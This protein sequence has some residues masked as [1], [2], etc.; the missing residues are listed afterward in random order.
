[1]AAKQDPGRAAVLGAIRQSLG[2]P[3]LS[4]PARR[5]LDAR[6]KKPPPN[7]VPAMAKGTP[8][9]LVD[10]F[11]AMAEAAACTVDRVSEESAVPGAVARYLR[12]GNLPTALTMAPD[13]WLNGLDWQSQPMLEIRRGAPR[14]QDLVGLTPAYAAVAESGSLVMASG[15]GHPA[16]LNFL[17]DYH[18]VALKA[19]QVVGSLEDIWHA[20]RKSYRAG[21]GVVLPRTINLITGPSRTGDIELT[22]H[23]GAHG[24]RSLHV[25]LI[26][27]V[28]EA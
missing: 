19:S 15:P 9:A 14:E 10:R 22:I 11:V 17:P 7:I 8:R 28:V 4:V 13:N 27:D 1:M 6:V 23:L 20:L 21:R 3:A 2:R 5:E 26:D 18:L 16:T 12:D 25:V 24:P